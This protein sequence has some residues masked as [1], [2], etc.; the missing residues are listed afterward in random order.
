M[1]NICMKFDYFNVLL[2]VALYPPCISS[3]KVNV[4]CKYCMMD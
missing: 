4:L 3:S 2:Q 1:I